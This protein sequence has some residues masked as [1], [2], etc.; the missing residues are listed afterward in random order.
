MTVQAREAH[1]KGRLPNAAMPH[2]LHPDLS[3]CNANG[4]LIFLDLRQDR[5]FCLPPCLE[6]AFVDSL[7]NGDCPDRESLARLFDLGILVSTLPPSASLLQQSPIEAPARSF[8]EGS[9]SP[10]KVWISSKLEVATRVGL[11]QLALRSRPLKDVLS[12]T[13]RKREQLREL[14]REE[15]R[16]E[17]ELIKAARLFEHARPQIPIRTCCLLDSLSL[18]QFLT[19]RRLSASLVFGVIGQPF[20]AHCWIQYRDAVVNDTL[21]NARAHTPIRVF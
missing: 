2:H 20:S 6:Q 13:V 19:A 12:A 14:E 4:Q 5:Y 1:R 7:A 21:G 15:F 16:H 11:T 9:Y 17:E 3:F 18:L 8:V 10:Q